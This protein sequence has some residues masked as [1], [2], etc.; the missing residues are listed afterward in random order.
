[1]PYTKSQAQ[2]GR[3]SILSIGTTGTTPTFSVIG[4]V[5][6]ASQSGSQWGTEDVTNFESGNDQEL[7]FHWL[8]IASIMMPVNSLLKPHSLTV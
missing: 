6:T 1:M 8:A 4:E 2:S 7:N 3:G 5:K